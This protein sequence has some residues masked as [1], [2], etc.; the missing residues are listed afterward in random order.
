KITRHKTFFQIAALQRSVTILVLGFFTDGAS[1]VSTGRI[2]EMRITRF[3]EQNSGSI[4]RLCP[5]PP[6]HPRP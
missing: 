4:Y 2:H 6:Q 1:V 3:E 5:L